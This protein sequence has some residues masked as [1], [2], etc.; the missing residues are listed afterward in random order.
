MSGH[1]SDRGGAPKGTLCVTMG[2]FS[3]EVKLTLGLRRLGC[4]FKFVWSAASKSAA[5][6]RIIRYPM[7]RAPAFHRVPQRLTH[8]S[9]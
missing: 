7:P 1:M 9:S 2:S 5:R 8:C 3:G 6:V 4:H